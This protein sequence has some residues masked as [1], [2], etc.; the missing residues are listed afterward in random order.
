MPRPSVQHSGFIIPNAKDVAQPVMAEPDRI[1]F[2]TV[3]NA[4][5]GV[6]EGCYVAIAGMLATTTGGVAI[7]NGDLV[8]VKPGEVSISNGGAQ[9]RFD[10]I[11]TDKDG[12]LK[13][14]RGSESLDPVFPDL[15]LDNTVLAAIFAPAGGP[16]GSPPTYENHVMDKRKFLADALLTKVDATSPLIDNRNGNGSL[17]KVDGKGLTAWDGD[18]FL[19]RSGV[20]TLQVTRHLR[21]DGDVTAGGGVRASNLSASGTIT[22]SNLRQ[23]TTRPLN[24]SPGDLFQHTTTGQIYIWQKGRW[25]E[26]A[27]LDGIVPV[28]TVITSMQSKEIMRDL[29]WF[30][31]DGTAILESEAPALF[32]IDALAG[33]RS[34]DASPNRTL[35]IPSATR[36]ILLTDFTGGAG[37][38]GGSGSIT[39][40]EANLPSHKHGVATQTGGGTALSGSM[41]AA[42]GHN[43]AMTWSGVHGHPVTDNG[44]QH[45]GMDFPVNKAGVISAVWGGQNKVDA[46]FNDRSHT[47]SVELLWWTSAAFSNVT[48]GT[49]GS[50]HIHSLTSAG[51]HTHTISISGTSAHVH[52]MTENSVGS[53]EPV[54]VTPPF[55][56]VYA[57]IRA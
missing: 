46:L 55:L 10:L 36:R 14:I 2:N 11:V 19:K 21:I 4:R 29:G 33:Y 40:K 28:G 32:D 13:L 30:P 31:L 47:Y 17:F 3:A 50:E 42:G 54:D 56:S 16:P 9:D 52:N 49:A 15:P 8:L 22:G 18:T 51:D 20:E 1:D 43:H 38:L 48:V 7:I 34:T 57:Y 12:T 41:S 24:A 53:S 39:L 27:T 5:W 45:Y 37:K 35:N 25:Q 26:L 6:I 23:G 44:H